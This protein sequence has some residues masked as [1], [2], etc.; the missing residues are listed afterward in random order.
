MKKLFYKVRGRVIDKVIW[1]YRIVTQSHSDKISR[2]K[3]LVCLFFNRTDNSFPPA[4]EKFRD[5]AYG[6]GGEGPNPDGPGNIHYWDVLRV[7]KRGG[8]FSWKIRFDVD[9]D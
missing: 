7:T 6:G 1:T 5:V 2:I 8:L 9:S 4:Y 3:A